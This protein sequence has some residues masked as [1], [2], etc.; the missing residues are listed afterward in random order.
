MHASEEAGL[1]TSARWGGRRRR[2]GSAAPVDFGPVRV[3]A[4]DDTAEAARGR[5]CAF[6]RW[7]G[8]GHGRRRRG[9]RFRDDAGASG[10]MM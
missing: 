2:A 6:A 4:S 3:H 1:G 10:V 7:C 9:G 8:D 5:G